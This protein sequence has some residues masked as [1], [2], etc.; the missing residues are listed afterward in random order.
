MTVS[1]VLETIVRV[2]YRRVMWMKGHS[3]S[4]DSIFDA[5]V[6]HYTS[7]KYPSQDTL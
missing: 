3:F 7:H 1:A 2:Y 6:S 5:I 4:D